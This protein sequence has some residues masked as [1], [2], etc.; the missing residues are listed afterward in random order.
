MRKAFTG[1]RMLILNNIGDGFISI[2]SCDNDK[3]SG[4]VLAEQEQ[5]K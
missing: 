5:I 1:K 3:I 2:A 4:V